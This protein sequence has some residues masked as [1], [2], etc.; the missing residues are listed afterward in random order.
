MLDGTVTNDAWFAFICGLDPC[1]HA[2]RDGQ[3]FPSDDCRDCDAGTIEGPHWLKANPNLGVSLPWQYVRERVAQAKRMPSEVS[4]VLRFNF[5]VWTQGVNRAI[6]MGRW[7]T[8]L[9]LPTEAELVGAEC[10]GCL[11]LGETDDF[12]AFGRLW[13]LSDG[14]VAVRCSSRLPEIAL[15]RYPNRPYDEWRRV[16]LLTSRTAR[17]RTTRRSAPA[18][19]SGSRADGI[20]VGVLR[21]Q[22]GARDG[23][24]P[25]RGGRRHGADD[26]GLRAQRG[27][28][29]APRA[30]HRRAPLPRQPADPARGWRNLVL[31]TGTKASGRIAKE[32]APEKID[33]MAALVMGIEGAIVR[34][35]R[36]P[37]P[38]YQ[39]FFLG[40]TP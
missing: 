6:D 22:N 2:A 20:T 5:C 23:A 16:G 29:A 34:R 33:G 18:S 40:G 15:D 7:A 26:A 9:P 38:E 1:E 11:D 32:R 19:S 30:C 3:W 37:P 36:Q 21:H 25:H 39:L 13:V 24:A 12:S 14:R 31:L 4:D 27:D 10:F 17:S 35:E 28:Q 8:C